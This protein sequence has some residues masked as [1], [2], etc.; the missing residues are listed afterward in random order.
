[1][2]APVR[3]RPT[4]RL[5]VRAGWK[6]FEFSKAFNLW[7]HTCPCKPQMNRCFLSKALPS[8]PPRPLVLPRFLPLALGGNFTPPLN[9]RPFEIPPFVWSMLQSRLSPSSQIRGGVVRTMTGR[10][11][12]Y[13]RHQS[14]SYGCWNTN[15]KTTVCQF[16]VMFTW[17][18]LS[19]NGDIKRRKFKN[20][21]FALVSSFLKSIVFMTHV[22]V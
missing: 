6:G 19:Y 10:A 2:L 5:N 12:E 3:P 21:C 9:H 17:F 22:T 18:E 4:P 1:M 20:V 16:S 15:R 8:S 14:L 11:P 13:L 7:E